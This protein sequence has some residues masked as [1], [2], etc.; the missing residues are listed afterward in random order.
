LTQQLVKVV[1]TLKQ[2]STKEQNAI[3]SLIQDELLWALSLKKSAKP[4]SNLS[5]EALN[6][7]LAGKT[8]K[9]KW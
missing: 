2:L 7:H 5:Q 9:G 1:E 6:E 3:A 4:L 8:K